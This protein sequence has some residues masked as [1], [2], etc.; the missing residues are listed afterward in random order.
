MDITQIIGFCT[1][2]SSELRIC[3]SDPDNREF[4]ICTHCNHK[5]KADHYPIGSDFIPGDLGKSTWEPT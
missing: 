2:C 4:F 3:D 1:E 5:Q